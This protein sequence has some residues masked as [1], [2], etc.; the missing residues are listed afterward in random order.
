MKLQL[1]VLLCSL[2]ASVGLIAQVP[3]AF[4]GAPFLSSEADV[5]SKFDL[6]ECRDLPNL[7]R[8]CKFQF[9]LA[10]VTVSGNLT[11]ERNAFVEVSGAFRQSAFTKIRDIFLAAHGPP[12]SSEADHL[13]WTGL[14]IAADLYRV[15]PQTSK[16]NVMDSG[17][18]GYARALDLALRKYQLRLESIL[19]IYKINGNR[20]EADETKQKAEHEYERDKDAAECER[21][22]YVP[23]AASSFSITVKEYDARVAARR[24]AETKRNADSIN[25]P[26][27]GRDP[28]HSPAPPRDSEC[29]GLSTIRLE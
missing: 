27:I 11:F 22:A 15:R 19:Q 6:G 13:K 26:A 2:M 1:R 7:E 28:P 17:A 3:D 4:R 20:R 23:P 29:W 25:G 24:A 18:E 16:A 12:P 10:G 5:R 21:Q 8:A 9:L 14:V